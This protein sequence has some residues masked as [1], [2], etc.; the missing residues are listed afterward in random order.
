[1]G[2]RVSQPSHRSRARRRLRPLR[3]KSTSNRIDAPLDAAIGNVP[4]ECN[5]HVEGV[6]DPDFEEGQQDRRGVEQRR[7]LALQVA[8]D[9]TRKQRILSVSPQDRKSTRLNSSHTVISYA[10][11]CLKK[12]KTKQY[13]R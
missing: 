10:V 5:Q 3:G 11:F 4:N 7:E 1:M 2:V 12:K 9:G 6:C 8:P 13:I